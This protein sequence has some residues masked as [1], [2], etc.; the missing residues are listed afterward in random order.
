MVVKF[1]R[2]PWQ[3]QSKIL[4]IIIGG[5]KTACLVKDNRSLGGKFIYRTINQ[6][7]AGEREYIHLFTNFKQAKF[8]EIGD[9]F[10]WKISL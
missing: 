8:L 4:P 9:S 3:N 10:P 2:Q 1:Y 5:H 6:H 7:E